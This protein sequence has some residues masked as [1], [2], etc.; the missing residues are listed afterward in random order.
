MLHSELLSKTSATAESSLEIQRTNSRKIVELSQ[1]IASLKDISH[2][3]SRAS[4]QLS[5]VLNLI[6]DATT[7]GSDIRHLTDCVDSLYL[8]AQGWFVPGF[9][10]SDLRS[11]LF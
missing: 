7:N 10:L 4:A 3:A 1:T 6:R 5:D 8:K 11:L 9:A 2:E